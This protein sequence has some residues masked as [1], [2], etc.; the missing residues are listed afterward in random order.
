MSEGNTHVRSIDRTLRIVQALQE[1]SRGTVTEISNHVGLPKST[2]YNHLQ[3]LY[4]NEYVSRSGEEYHLGLRFLEHGGYIRNQMD[5]FHVAKPEVEELAAETGE[6]VNML[7]EEHGRGVY[8]YRERGEQAVNLDSYIGKRQ[9]LH[10]TAFGK[11]MLAYMAPERVDEI[12]DKHGM[13]SRTEHTISDREELS[14]ELETI[15]DQGYAIDDEES[16][17]GLRCVAAPILTQDDDVLGAVSIS[18]PISRISGDRFTKE[19][20]E[21]LRSTTNVIEINITYS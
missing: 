6:L 21:L 4:E 13:I 14:Q 16:L 2:V 15:R 7:V 20:P 19:I 11:A 8:L 1:L 3:T 5:I 18:G 10:S 9:Y 12:L 17:E